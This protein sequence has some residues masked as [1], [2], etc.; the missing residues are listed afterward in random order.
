MSGIRLRQVARDGVSEL[1]TS[2][3]TSDPSFRGQPQGVLTTSGQTT[4]ER[5]KVSVQVPFVRGLVP[6]GSLKAMWPNTTEICC[7]AKSADALRHSITPLG[8]R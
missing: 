5:D 6:S 3:I 8:G 7:G 2:P 4:H 1:G